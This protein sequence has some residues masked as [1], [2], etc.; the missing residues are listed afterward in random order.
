M[1]GT[2]YSLWLS[3]AHRTANQMAGQVT[4]FWAGTLTA[5]ARRNQKAMLRAMTAPTAAPRS[6]AQ[7]KPKR[8]RKGKAR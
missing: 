4:G 3:M 5:A 1:K 7:F 6:T 8:P 2:P